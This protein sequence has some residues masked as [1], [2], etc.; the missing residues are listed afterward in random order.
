[1]RSREELEDLLGCP[2]EHLECSLWYLRERG[3][4]V[5]ADNGRHSITAPDFDEAEASGGASM[6][7]D[8]LLTTSEMG[9][10]QAAAS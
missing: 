9:L 3:W 5:R 1:M 2:R 7:P 4:I 6:R 8:R 10:P